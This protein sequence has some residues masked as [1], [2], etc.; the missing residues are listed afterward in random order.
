MILVVRWR[1]DG[2]KR[3]PERPG[4]L[5]SG[6]THQAHRT[7]SEAAFEPGR[8]REARSVLAE[9]FPLGK[10]AREWVDTLLPA[11]LSDDAGERQKAAKACQKSL[12]KAGDRQRDR[13]GHPDAMDVVVKALD[14]SDPAVSEAAA[15]ATRLSMRYYEDPRAYQPLVGLLRAAK[16]NTRR[17]AVEGVQRTGQTR[18]G[19]AHSAAPV[20]QV[21]SGPDRG[22]PYDHGC[23]TRR[24]SFADDEGTGDRA[25][26]GPIRFLRAAHAKC[27]PQRGTRHGWNRCARPSSSL[28]RRRRAGPIRKK[29]AE[30]VAFLE[31]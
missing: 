28:A 25:D 8:E 7:L 1:R 18:G 12:V 4:T 30:V 29:I 16:A 14:S 21:G 27:H 11:L 2:P 9:L 6:E 31:S 26:A 15:F 23:R 13:I 24:S 19:R 20:G 17:W 5:C 22:R 10:D 3:D